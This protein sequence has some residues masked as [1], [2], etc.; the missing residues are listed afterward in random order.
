[1]PRTSSLFGENAH[2]RS[3]RDVKEERDIGY[4]RLRDRWHNH[5]VELR[6]TN[7]KGELEDDQIFIMKVQGNDSTHEVA[8]SKEELLR[9]LRYV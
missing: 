2:K 9:F 1:M 3:A 4:G 6:W 8:L 5:K 7:D